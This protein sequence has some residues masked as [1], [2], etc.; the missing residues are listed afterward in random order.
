[1]G[2][3]SRGMKALIGRK[4]DAC[5][6]GSLPNVA[7]KNRLFYFNFCATILEKLLLK[8]KNG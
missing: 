3:V 8:P 4:S 5:N 2:G 7:M 6:S 1:M